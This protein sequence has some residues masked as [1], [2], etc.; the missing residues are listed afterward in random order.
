MLMLL[1]NISVLVLFENI[2]NGI[3]RFLKFKTSKKSFMIYKKKSNEN[4]VI[5]IRGIQSPSY[6]SVFI[7]FIYNSKKLYS[8]KA[9]I[10]WASHRFRKE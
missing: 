2:F 4:L 3:G 5:C 7:V 9:H 1:M 10:V 6:F 8:P